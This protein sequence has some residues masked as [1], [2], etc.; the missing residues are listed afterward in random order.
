MSR[1]DKWIVLGMGLIL[2][3]I[4][5]MQGVELATDWLW[6]EEVGYPSVFTTRLA[7]AL[8]LGGLGA[9]LFFMVLY[10][11]LRWARAARPRLV[12]ISER[13]LLN[14]EER[15]AV[16]RLMRPALFWGTLFLS[17]IAGLMV[18][19]RWM[20]WLQLRHGVPFGQEDPLFG[21][22]IGFYVFAWPFWMWLVRAAFAALGGVAVAVVL[23]YLYEE[24]IQ[25]QEEAIVFAPRARNHLLFLAALLLFVRA[26][27]YGLSR[28]S[29]LY[30]L[31]GVVQGGAGYAAVHAQLPVIS[32][33]TGLCVLAG[34][35]CLYGMG[36]RSTRPAVYTVLAV[37]LV[38]LV[39][40][41]AY[42]Q[43]IQRIVVQPNELER[44]RPFLEHH[45]RATRAAYGLDNIQ[46]RSF[47]ASQNL[48]PAD[49]ANNDL[50]LRNIRL[51]DHRPLRQTLEQ[52][53]EIRSYYTF[54]DVDI[55]RYRLGGEL[56]Q[57][58][59]AA[60]ELDHQQLDR[61]AQTWVNEHLIYTHGY[62]FCMV[63]ANQVRDHLPVWLVRDI[64][65][66]AES[67]L[68]PTR[69]NP[70]ERPEIYFGEV[71]NRPPTP[72]GGGLLPRGPGLRPGASRQPA[73][74]GQGPAPPASANPGETLADYLLVGTA[75]Q[76]FDY[77]T[78]G[79][80]YAFTRYSGRAGVPIGSF[81][82]RLLFALRFRSKDLLFTQGLRPDSRIIFHRQINERVRTIA[83]F[84][85]LD[86]DPYLV[87]DRGRLFWI[88][89]A[90]T[91]TTRYPYSRPFPVAQWP[92]NYLRNSVKVVIDAYHG[93]VDFYA[94]PDSNGQV[95]PLLRTYQRIFPGLFKPLAELPP[96]LRAHLR[97]P[98]GLFGIQAMMY[99]SYHMR[100][101]TTFYNQED[102]WEIA[103]EATGR[104]LVKGAASPAGNTTSRTMEPYYVIMRLPQEQKE[105]FLLMLP[106]TPAGR[107]NMIAWLCARC[108]PEHYGEM[109]ALQMPKQRNV[110]GPQQIG[111]RINQDSRIS[112]A[113]SLWGEHGSEVFLGN[114]L[115]IPVEESLLY[116]VPLYLQAE[117]NPVPQFEQVIVAYGD[118]KNSQI[119]MASTLEEALDQLFGKRP[120]ARRERT[121][122]PLPPSPAAP[123]GRKAPPAAES[124]QELVRRAQQTFERMQQAPPDW[125]R[126]AEEA[127]RLRKLL[128]QIGQRAAP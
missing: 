87:L 8:K 102:R 124:L 107:Q 44:E 48:T 61:T 80:K 79:D 71:V 108:D 30:S 56:Q 120:T 96:G 103:R 106:F 37:L 109:L 24:A 29:V 70:V 57:V 92:M 19:G 75:Q 98:V 21:R 15:E 22:D 20:L 85:M 123:P 38:A 14:P 55:D 100:E 101:V 112:K 119:V 2:A 73:P 121:S 104:T 42:P 93:T 82:R 62:G 64:P 5:L 28:F 26:A 35:A 7:T 53:Q 18:G 45:I 76:E 63:P 122:R 94:V 49:L 65:P 23:V 128:Q 127:D 27:F 90:Y 114:L 72:T 118:E 126:Y 116:V 78:A 59:L 50:T 117:E 95:E 91:T 11:N 83:P 81:G 66:V 86:T 34:L 68:D 4:L 84:L 17:L 67:V 110:F 51:W 125:G 52:L 12:L 33:L 6:F 74:T 13:T 69:S 9:L 58:M 3:G 99:T 111:A 47:A 41:K 88:L 105:E 113:L 60:R 16:E 40:W 54:A 31:R 25:I 97:Y 115:V 77:P 46:T 10:T 32:L 36:Q 89:D 39:G 43:M 1:R